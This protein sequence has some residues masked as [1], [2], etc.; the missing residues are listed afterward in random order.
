Y[1]NEIPG[2]QHVTIGEADHIFVPGSP[3]NYRIETVGLD[4]GTY[5]LDVIRPLV[6]RHDD[7]T[8][9]RILVPFQ[10]RDVPTSAGQRRTHE[11]D[12]VAAGRIA[13]AK[14]GE[15]DLE[16]A[17]RASLDTVAIVS[18]P[19]VGGGAVEWDLIALWVLAGVAVVSFVAYVVV[20]RRTHD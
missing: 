3:G 16:S 11:E 17:L 18:A 6:V 5:N 12:V 10:Y 19:A 13:S 9:E 8:F 2:A 7:G 15:M 1:E 14:L 4:A 20:R